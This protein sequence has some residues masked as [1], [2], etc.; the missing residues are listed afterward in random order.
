MKV[1]RGVKYLHKSNI[2]E[3]ADGIY[4]LTKKKS[5]PQIYHHKWTFVSSD[6]NGFSVEQS[7]LRSEAWES[8]LKGVNKAKIGY[9]DYWKQC[10]YSVGMEL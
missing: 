8:K 6:Y 4:K 1:V 5:N 7:K 2:K 10:L 9:K 3:T